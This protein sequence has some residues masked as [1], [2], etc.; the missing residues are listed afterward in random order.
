MWKVF[1]GIMGIVALVPFV[2]TFGT[3]LKLLV[4]RRRQGICVQCG[5]NLKGLTELRCPECGTAFEMDRSKLQGG[6]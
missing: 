4:R 1:L 2:I 5:Y 6:E 3:L